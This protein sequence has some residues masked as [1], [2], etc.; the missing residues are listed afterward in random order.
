MEKIVSWIDD[1]FPLTKVR[2]DLGEGFLHLR[3]VEVVHLLLIRRKDVRPLL[4]CV[5]D[6]LL[7]QLGERSGGFADA[8]QFRLVIRR[9]SAQLRG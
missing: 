7:R 2:V 3:Q 8:R 5:E 1:R 9:C 6:G 4:I